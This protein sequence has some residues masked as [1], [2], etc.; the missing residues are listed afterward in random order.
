MAAGECA[1]AISATVAVTPV[2]VGGVLT[3]AGGWLGGF[4]AD[5][6]RFVRDER[7]LARAFRGEIA[8]LRDIVV[9]RKYT[10]YLEQAIKNIETSKQ[11]Y[12][13]AIHV[14]RSYLS[15]Y[16][17]NVDKIGSLVAPLPEDLATFYTCANSILEDLE[18]VRLGELGVSPE[19]QLRAYRELLTML[20]DAAGLADKLLTEIDEKY[21]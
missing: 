5:R 3:F 21:S 17:K 4:L 19:E 8:A 6:R 20:R 7:N 2:V 15:V 11:P 13:F 9:R 1:N 10:H 16:D 12:V 14:R 18:A